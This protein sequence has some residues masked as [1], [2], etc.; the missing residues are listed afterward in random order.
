V[1]SNPGAMGVWPPA[2]S[3]RRSSRA[4]NASLKISPRNGLEV[5]L[6]M[7]GR[8][9][10]VPDL[11]NEKR[12]WI[13]KNAHLL[14]KFVSTAS[15]VQLPEHL[16]LP[17]CGEQWK[18]S[19]LFSPG[20]TKIILR[21]HSELT[22]MGNI[23]DIPACFKVLRQWL[24]QKAEQILAPRLFLL[25][26]ELNL[27]FK[28]LTIRSQKTRW[29]S[30]SSQKSINL[31]F[32]LIFLSADIVRHIMIHELCHTV[33]LNHSRKFWQL[34]ARHDPQWRI[35][36]QASRQVESYLPSWIEE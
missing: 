13:E 1:S 29:G 34:V 22:V 9:I 24:G 16:H 12:P 4:R 36:H 30:C 6:P 5:I 18:I 32:K 19:Y 3:I 11:L 8:L 10:D 27:P 31:N 20:K 25:S 14:Q 17:S 35:N 33:H 23:D 28:N 21:P 26:Q 15:P 7:R 2:H